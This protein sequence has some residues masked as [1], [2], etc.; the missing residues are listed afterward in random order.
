MNSCNCSDTGLQR[1][2]I[3]HPSNTNYLL[4]HKSVVDYACTVHWSRLAWYGLMITESSLVYSHYNGIVQ[5]ATARSQ[6][7]CKEPPYSNKEQT[8]R[9]INEECLK[10]NKMT[11]TFVAGRTWLWLLT[12]PLL[13]HVTGGLWFLEILVDVVWPHVTYKATHIQTHTHT[14]Q[15]WY[16]YLISS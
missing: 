4:G 8:S 14:F 12:W 2:Q 6:S 3:R 10:I 7:V 11:D 5:S 16:C 9:E 13:C 1:Q 15:Q